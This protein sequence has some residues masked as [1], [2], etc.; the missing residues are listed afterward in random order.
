MT[1]AIISETRN[2][3]ARLGVDPSCVEGGTLAA[4]S[5]LTGDVIGDVH[6][7]TP[8]EAKRRIAEAHRAFLAWRT[9]PAPRRG[10]FVRQLGTELRTHKDALGRLVAIE[11]GKV[12]SE[13]WGEV[14]E[15]IDICDFAV[16]LS[17]AIR[18]LAMHW[19]GH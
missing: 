7:T 14:Q 1:H 3:L 10:D 4:R 5:P 13:G 8:D 15:M 9:V 12:L 6:E 2:L 16:G 18:W 19:S 11:V 17:L